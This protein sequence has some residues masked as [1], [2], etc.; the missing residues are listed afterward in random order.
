MAVT[1]KWP[2]W[3]NLNGLH[4]E[5]A[6]MGQLKWLSPG[7]G[8]SRVQMPDLTAGE[9]DKGRECS[10]FTKGGRAKPWTLDPKTLNQHP[11][12]KTPNPN[13]QNSKP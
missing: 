11:Q 3:D 7:N 13:P 5:M 1:W 10:R 9:S 8:Q 12:T 2:K 4:L 6:K